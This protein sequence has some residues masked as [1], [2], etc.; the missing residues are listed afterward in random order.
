MTGIWLLIVGFLFTELPQCDPCSAKETFGSII[1]GLSLGGTVVVDYWIW[2]L[3][4]R[5]A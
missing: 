2:R 1:M 3:G 5:A 4:R